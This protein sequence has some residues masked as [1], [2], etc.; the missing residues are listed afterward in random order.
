MELRQLKYFVTIAK[1]KQFVKAANYLNLS[2]SALSQQINLLEKEI[3]VEL[4]DKQKRKINRIVELTKE[5]KVFLKDAQNILD[6][7]ESALDKIRKIRNQKK[8]L[9]LGIYRMIHNQRVI[10]ILGFLGGKFPNHEIKIEEYETHIAVQ[11]SLNKDFL[12][13]GITVKPILFKKLDY[14]PLK[15]SELNILLYKGHI[16]EEKNTLELENLKNENW[17]EIN[18]S[19]H[20]IYEEIENYCNA[21]GF[22]RESQIVQKISSLELLCHFVSQKKGIAFVPSFLDTSMFPNLIIK[23]IATNPLKFEQCLAFLKKRNYFFDAAAIDINL[24]DML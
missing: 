19:V 11:E 13:F 6:L 20:P 22:K 1:E 10:D 16:L 24:M 8:V 2:Q 15:E 23:R 5:G 7:S 12:D 18:E 14:I 21:A 9:R 4:F 3:G 17:I